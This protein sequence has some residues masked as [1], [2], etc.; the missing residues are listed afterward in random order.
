M[1]KFT[2]NPYSN[3]ALRSQ[4]AEVKYKKS[5]GILTKKNG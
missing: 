4:S 3:A 2:T 1:Y 5:N